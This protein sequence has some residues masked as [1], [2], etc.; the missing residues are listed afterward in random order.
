MAIGKLLAPL[1][2]R[3]ITQ[4]I[5]RPYVD[6]IFDPLFNREVTN[7][8]RN[9]YGPIGAVPAGY[10]AM[11]ENALTGQKGILGPGMGILSTF[12]RSMDKADDFILGSLTEGVN[13]LGQVTGGTNEAPQNPFARIFVDDYDYQGAKL[14]AAAG[15]AMARLAGTR[16]PLDE[17]DF[18][19]FGD[20]I[21]GTTLDLATDPGI[22]GGQLTRLNPNSPVGQVGQILSDYDDTMANIA[23]NMAFPGGK[24]LIDKSLNKIKDFVK[25]A[26]SASPINLT[27]KHGKP[28]TTILNPYTGEFSYSSLTPDTLNT[29]RKMTDDITYTLDPIQDADLYALKE[30]IY[31]NTNSFVDKELNK[32]V[33][34]QQKYQLDQANRLAKKNE[35]VQ[36]IKDTAEKQRQEIFTSSFEGM[37]KHQE[38]F[39]QNYWN[40][41][42]SA[43]P[44]FPEYF[45]QEDYNKAIEDY[46]KAH[47]KAEQKEIDEYASKIKE[48]YKVHLDD[49]DEDQLLKYV[50]DNFSEYGQVDYYGKPLPYGQFYESVKSHIDNG[51]LQRAKELVLNKMTKTGKTLSKSPFQF[52]PNKMG[53]QSTLA[54]DSLDIINYHFENFLNKHPKGLYTTFLK[55]NLKDVKYVPTD[56]F[57][58]LTKYSR[59][60]N[61]KTGKAITELSGKNFNNLLEVLYKRKLPN[62]NIDF[63][64]TKEEVSESFIPWVRKN[65]DNLRKT[66]LGRDLIDLADNL[67]TDVFDNI[68]YEIVHKNTDVDIIPKAYDESIE[69]IEDLDTFYPNSTVSQYDEVMSPSKFLNQFLNKE[70]FSPED[71]KTYA[72]DFPYMDLTISNNYLKNSSEY[73]EYMEQVNKI[74]QKIKELNIQ[75]KLLS[76]D[77]KINLK[78]LDNEIA[79][80]KARLKTL[81]RNPT[82][83]E[84]MLDTYYT[85]AKKVYWEKVRGTPY[86]Y[87]YTKLTPINVADAA[88]KVLK[89]PKLD[90]YVKVA[91]S[92]ATFSPEDF[93][94]VITG[95]FSLQDNAS[96]DLFNKT[97]ESFKASWALPSGISPIDLE[98]YVKT[99][100]SRQEKTLFQQWTAAVQSK[101]ANKLHTRH[102]ALHVEMVK[103]LKKRIDS[104]G[105]K[106]DKHLAKYISIQDIRTGANISGKNFLESL[107]A[108]NG[109]KEIPI[110]PRFTTKE[111]ADLAAKLL[112]ENVDKVNANGNILKFVD[113]KKGDIRRLAVYFDFENINLKKDIN[114]LYGLFGKKDLNLSDVNLRTAKSIHPTFKGY[115]E[116]DSLFADMRN[117]SESLATTIGYE[118]FDPNYI[119]HAM[120]DSEE[121]A[122]VFS[123]I[124]KDLGIDRKK[125]DAICQA[126]KN[127]DIAS[128][129]LLFGS[130]P[131]ERSHLGYFSQYGAGYSTKLNKIYS[132]TFTEG[133]FDDSNVQTF[134]DLFL[135]D[136]FKIKNNFDDV[137]TLKK[138]LFMTDKHGKLSGNLDNLSLVTPRYN[139]TGKLIGFTR[140]NKFS[141][142]SLN[143]AFNDENAILVPDAVIGSLDRL[144]KKDARMSNKVYAFINKY[145]TVPFKFGTLANP[146]FLAGNIQ[147][148]YFKQAVELSKKYGT[149]L[150]E[151]LTNVAMSMRQVTKLNNDFADIFDGYRTWLKN[152]DLKIITSSTKPDNSYEKIFKKAKGMVDTLTPD[153]VISDSNLRNSFNEYSK[154]F[155]SESDRRI[156]KMYVFLNNSQ[157]STI[158]K[159]N[160][161]D[162]EDVKDL[163]NENPYDVPTNIVERIFYGNPAPKV[164]KVDGKTVTEASTGFR[165]WGLF[166]NNPISNG[167][168]KSSNTIENWMRSATILNDLQHQG[169]TMDD[170]CRILDLDSVTEK[171]VRDKFKMSMNEAINTMH[172]ANFDY[173]NVSG[174]MNK[175]SYIL[176]FPTFYLKN[177]AFWAD[178]FTNKPQLIDNV[179]S[180]HEGLWAG[181]DTSKDEFTAEAKG[182]GAV[183]IGQQNKHLTG[184]VK[185]TPYTS[186]FGAFNAI[187]NFKEDF[188]YR[189][190]PILRPIARHLQDPKD[191]K[192]RPYNM[193]QYQKN[194]TKNDKEFSNLAY[195]FHQL[196]PYER[197]INTGLRTPGKIANNSYQLSDFLPSMFQ[198]DFRKKSK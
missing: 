162:L 173:D 45:K 175:V 60:Q 49:L 92:L 59:K 73:K 118:K 140:Y 171:V 138:A 136:N 75:K 145:L 116:L 94:K 14:M 167:I 103:N 121:A 52:L 147:D 19:S 16:T 123:G 42:S 196:N 158:F 195:M 111:Q 115:E 93:T 46:K 57:E 15:N 181:K 10:A 135:T 25:G 157:T 39:T 28:Q 146:G 113:F 192:Y 107:W 76:P 188:A 110:D 163:L 17:S 108:S 81:K 3:T 182:R 88:K 137:E 27:T 56:I 139:D 90:D 48:N 174:L 152:T 100:G 12:G 148:A 143:K 186:M 149:D 21:A 38:D 37:N 166:L 2:G 134:F 125:L 83:L 70:T 68:N 127:Q 86:A 30:D 62:E 117:A 1:N 191:I 7:Y 20:K 104:I 29:L 141:D 198:P 24:A 176:P 101:Y 169:Y 114:K 179:I 128:N 161:L 160:N 156:A 132:S 122:K 18:T 133:M 194:I 11:L 109:F 130:I 170:I 190:N 112:K 84:Q 154:T 51:D 6:D 78:M 63:I 85:P 106:Y 72:E 124:Y 5:E 71:L 34:D 197:F 82:I 64:P 66:Q 193:E 79:I 105:D 31:A 36:R 44:E 43:N 61:I 33:K 142:I 80:E 129:K 180:A 120:E 50:Y 54:K 9:L 23:G 95:N 35:A 185:Q 168:L 98:K 47:S 165:S 41:N 74:N 119:S 126:L 155:L 99:F 26:S 178:I 177:L 13:A 4:N 69:N 32:F 77:S 184:I 164:I 151:E 102:G 40:D 131:L 22:M 172:A 187:N 67:E 144:C 8:Y 159:N 55:D 189:T 53:F 183:P 87:D 58:E 89:E 150:S 96:T 153:M 65:N 97:F 91:D